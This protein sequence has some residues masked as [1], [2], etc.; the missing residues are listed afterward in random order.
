MRRVLISTLATAGLLLFGLAAHAQEG[1]RGGHIFDRV[2]ADLDRAATST[3]PFTGDRDRIMVVRRDVNEFQ[4]EQANGNYDPAKLD[5]IIGA[6]QRVVDS[7]RMPDPDRNLLIAD[8]HELREF[9]GRYEHSA[10]PV[11]PSATYNSVSRLAAGGPTMRSFDDW[12]VLY[13]QVTGNPGPD[14]ASL[15]ARAGFQRTQ[16]ISI[17]EWW[18]MMQSA[19]QY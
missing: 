17:G 2:G 9:R 1:Q 4:N 14:P 13:Q 19:G 15:L 8:L 11:N 3:L 5:N 6:L 7:N 10:T 16:P 12:N 18:S